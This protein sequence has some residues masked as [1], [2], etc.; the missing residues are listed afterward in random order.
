MKQNPEMK[1]IFITM[2]IP[3]GTLSKLKKKFVVDINDKDEVLPAEELI[4]RANKADA[5]LSLLTDKFT[6]EVIDKLSGVKMIANC[7]VGFDNINIPAATKN[8]IVV[9]N[10]PGVLTD[11]TADFAF[12]LMVSAARRI[13]ESDKYTRA[14]KFKKW[15]LLLMLGQD[16]YGKTIGLV[17]LGRIGKAMA[18]RCL[19]FG[20]KVLYYD[21]KRDSEFE[22]LGNVEYK[23]LNTLLQESDFISLHVPL[24]DSTRH[25]IGEQQFK[26]MKK[27]AV[28]VNTARGPVIDEKALIK[29][30]KEKQIF[31]AGLDVYEFEPQIPKELMELDNVILAPHIASASID[32]RT[33][34]AELA[35]DNLIAFFSTGK[36]NT[37]VNPDVLNLVAK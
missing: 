10:T 13:V 14:G 6:P 2:P 33:K 15:G 8:G 1:K 24:L 11:T 21:A 28:L 5:V 26:M 23:D 19:G 12:T 16:I 20:M 25:M 22:N 30:L 31:A 34:M 29:A 27:S 35:A 32:T 7:A 37:P 18:Q 3:D 36:P 17:G 9:T 4:S